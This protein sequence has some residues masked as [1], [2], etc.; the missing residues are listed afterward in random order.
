MAR[1]P[2]TNFRVRVKRDLATLPETMIF[3]IQQQTILGD[4]D[5]VLC[6]RGRFVALELKSVRGKA[7]A[8]QKYK[9]ESVRK[10]GGLAFEVYP[11]TWAEVFTALNILARG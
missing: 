9:L 5:F 2:E 10:S 8:L 7:S 1:K 4:P 6:V 11:K 3:P